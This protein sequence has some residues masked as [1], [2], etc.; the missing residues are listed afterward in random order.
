MKRGY[1]VTGGDPAWGLPVVASTAREA[2]RI[3]W[4]DWEFE[5]DC[6]WIDLR[7]GWRRKARIDDLPIGVVEDDMIAWDRKLIDYVS[8]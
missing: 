2:K 5:F 8:R 1:I 4:K 3:A 7:V 6:R